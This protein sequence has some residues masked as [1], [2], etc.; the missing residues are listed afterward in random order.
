MPFLYYT[1]S[2]KHIHTMSN[3]HVAAFTNIVHSSSAEA[4][5]NALVFVRN[6][7][8]NAFDAEQLDELTKM[9]A[10]YKL[11]ALAPVKVGRGKKATNPAAPKRKVAISGYALYSKENRAK[12]VAENKEAPTTEIMTLLGRAWKS[13]SD[14]EQQVYK[15]RAKALTEAAAAAAAV[16]PSPSAEAEAEADPATKPK[17][18]KAAPKIELEEKGE[19]VAAKGAVK[20]AKGAKKSK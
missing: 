17:A 1:L 3:A 20:A 19:E 7:A 5:D 13:L 11:T 18:T 14:D 12:I 6:H 2:N 9:F 8:D 16:P 15:D 10:E 4:L